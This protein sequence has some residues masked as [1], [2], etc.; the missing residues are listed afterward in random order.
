MRFFT[1]IILIF[2]FFQSC[3]EKVIIPE[4]VV[5]KSNG[6]PIDLELNPLL[7]ENESEFIKELYNHLGNKIIW[8]NSINRLN[9]IQAIENCKEDGLFP[10]DYHFKELKNYEKNRSKLDENKL[11]VFDLL[12]S[13][14]LKNLANHLHKGKLNPKDL[15][16]DWDLPTKKEISVLKISEAIENKE[17]D[18]LLQAVS[19][20]NTIYKNL[21]LEL[22]NVLQK[23]NYSIKNTDIETK[24]E[25]NDSAEVIIN[26]KQK[27]LYWGDLKTEN[28]SLQYD[29]TSVVALKKF[30]KRNGL[31]PDGI[32]GKSTAK[33]LNLT[34]NQLIEKIIVNLERWKWFPDSF[35]ENY[36]F[37][38]IPNYR[39]DFIF[40][41]DTLETRRIIVGKPDRS[42][43]ILTSKINTIVF[44]PTWTV[45]PTILKED[46]YPSASEN[47]NYFKK[48]RIIILNANND[49]INPADWEANNYKKY[50]YVQK[51]GYNNSLGLVK[52]NFPN[53]FM[54]Y[55]HDTNHRDYFA[56]TNRALSSG[57]VRIENP[58]PFAN[59][60]LTREDEEKW[61]E[62]AIDTLIKKAE[63]I[64]IPIKKNIKIYLFYYTTWFDKDQIQI[65]NDI[66][67]YDEKLFQ[68]L[69]K[70][71]LTN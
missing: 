2:F 68:K 11:Q 71:T 43:P 44:N 41:N 39:L 66:Y 32:I 58:I 40:E 9:L 64:V 49:T 6:I 19:I 59:S 38:N 3:K 53:K 22:L 1:I 12:L 63:T 35:S 7:L 20:Q 5:V 18:K 17:V 28:T 45:P 26:I 56:L 13:N 34:K 69:R 52:F 60:I 10:E 8:T 24:I 55:L 51:A 65:R 61:K 33:A 4:D 42:T 46:L 67:N 62:S 27:L 29:S 47:L 54:V 57:C 31:I 70:T 15:Y 21:K 30:Q 14:A 16:D 48:N 25:P 50:K 36:I 23:P 37:I